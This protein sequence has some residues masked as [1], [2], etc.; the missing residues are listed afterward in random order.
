MRVLIQLLL[1]ILLLYSH[2][3]WAESGRPFFDEASSDR[4]DVADPEP[5]K[6]NQLVL[7]P[8]P[9]DDDLME[10]QVDRQD[11]PFQYY[12]DGKNL[13]VGD[14]NTVRFTLVIKSRS[15]ASNVSYEAV[16]CD[17]REFKVFAY[18]SR[19]RFKALKGALWEELKLTGYD[20]YRLD[21]RDFYL[22][23]LDT[24]RPFFEHE[25]FQ[26]LREGPPRIEETGDFL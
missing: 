8:Y 13:R 17:V 23:N 25:I 21:L 4:V 1:L 26:R 12:V 2:G 16:R 20:L 9:E 18:G 14:D 24:H 22:C 15:G 7:P 5:W 10:F 3:V 6:E 19:G 11:S